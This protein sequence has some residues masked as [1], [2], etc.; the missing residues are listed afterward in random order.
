MSFPDKD[1]A[2]IGFFM[3]DTARRMAASLY[4][5]IPGDSFIYYGEEIAM[6]GSSTDPDKR[7]GMYWSSTDKTGYVEKIPGQTQNNLPEKAVDEQLKDDNSLLNFYKRVIALKNQNPEIENGTLTVVDVGS[8]A[9]AGYICDANGSKVLVMF[10]A[11]SKSAKVT[12]PEDVFKINEVR[13]YLLADAGD[14][15]SPAAGAD[16]INAILGGGT[17]KEES[18]SEEDNIKEFSVSGQE[19][20]MPPFS[21]I[22]LK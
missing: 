7:A 9:A 4:I 10:N 17:A 13:G 8:K 19:I 22:V 11:G 5:L 18:K 14:N 12:V 15:Q 3:T 21:T 2:F 6:T 16:K 1:T 20:T